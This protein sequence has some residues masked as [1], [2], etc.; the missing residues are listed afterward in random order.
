MKEQGY[1]YSKDDK[2]KILIKKCNCT[3]NFKPGKDEVKFVQFLIEKLKNNKIERQFI[4][5]E[6]MSINYYEN[7]YRIINQEHDF[8][9]VYNIFDYILKSRFI[10]DYQKQKLISLKTLLL[11]K[12][13]ELKIKK[14]KMLSQKK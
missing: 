6:I 10:L 9:M 4:Y 7:F 5:H 12:E 11:K 1:Y 3:K 2:K 14:I 13:K 8:K